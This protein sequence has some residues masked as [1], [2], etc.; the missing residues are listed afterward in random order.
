M[1]KEKNENKKENQESKS[2]SD[3]PDEND[4]LEGEYKIAQEV[5]SLSDRIESAIS[6]YRLHVGNSNSEHILK[7]D[8]S[9]GGEIEEGKKENDGLD[10]GIEQQYVNALSKLQVCE[11]IM[12]KNGVY[13]HHY[14]YIMI[15]LFLHYLIVIYF[16]SEEIDKEIIVARKK[17]RRLVQEVSGIYDMLVFYL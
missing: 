17:L 13:Q 4:E 16:L 14:R 8:G 2:A 12:H 9:L 11:R 3:E 5:L 6:A 10:E 1:K 15:S 7:T